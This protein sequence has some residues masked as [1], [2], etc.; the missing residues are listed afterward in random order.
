[1]SNN[2]S[3]HEVWDENIALPLSPLW[4][5]LRRRDQPLACSLVRDHL[6]DPNQW[7]PYDGGPG[8]GGPALGYALWWGME[9]VVDCLLD[10]GAST[11]D[12]QYGH[13]LLGLA[14][15]VRSLRRMVHAGADINARHHS[16]K[17]SVLHALVRRA[18]P[19]LIVAALELGADIHHRDFLGATPLFEAGSVR[20]AEVLIAA[21]SD[22]LARDDFGSQAL[23]SAVIRG[24]VDLCRRL[25]EL[26]CDPS[27]TE[28]RPRPRSLVEYANQWGHPEVAALLD[29]AIAEAS[30]RK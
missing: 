7:G 10:A 20:V 28:D 6:Q 5:A 25:I 1:M 11:M 27:N 19:D 18:D 4:S 16:T 14:R 2:E 3:G 13:P 21:G 12:E 24:K 17:T 15:S 22:P 30:G 9:D 29:D 8:G 23:L 26:G